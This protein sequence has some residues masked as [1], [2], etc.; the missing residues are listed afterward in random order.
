VAYFGSTAQTF[1]DDNINRQTFTV[2][3]VVTDT[4]FFVEELIVGTPYTGSGTIYAGAWD[5]FIAVNN[6]LDFE[7]GTEVVLYDVAGTVEVNG[8]DVNGRALRVVDIHGFTL[9]V[10]EVIKSTS[11]PDTS[12]AKIIGTK[13]WN[14]PQAT[15]PRIATHI[16]ST[17]GDW[18]ITLIGEAT[19]IDGSEVR[20]Y[21]LYWET[22][23]ADHW[24][25]MSGI[26]AKPHM[27]QPLL[28]LSKID[29]N[30][31]DFTKPK[32]IAYFEACFFL[33]IV[34]QYRA[35]INDSTQVELIR[36]S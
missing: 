20:N 15:T 21:P 25:C 27:V 32:Y 4:V 19:E 28:R 10:D 17:G 3:E 36:L 23:V 26:I 9:E 13:E 8:Q 24:Q 22:L 14:E 6:P 31:L 35:D 2:S 11:Y 30:Q 7:E 1:D 12:N 29:I 5:R 18:P 34:D 16:V 33:S